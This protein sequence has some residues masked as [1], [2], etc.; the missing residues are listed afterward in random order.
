M[1]TFPETHVNVEMIECSI[2]RKMLRFLIDP[3]EMSS[4]FG[5]AE[6]FVPCV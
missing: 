1:N 4:G 5:T 3:G 2:P 6:N